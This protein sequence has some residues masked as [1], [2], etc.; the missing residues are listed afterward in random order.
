MKAEASILFAI[1]YSL[2][3]GEKTLGAV[4]HILRAGEKSLSAEAYILKAGRKLLEAVAY[5]LREVSYIPFWYQRTLKEKDSSLSP[6]LHSYFLIFLNGILLTS[7]YC[8]LVA[9]KT[10]FTY[11]FTSNAISTRPMLS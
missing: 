2:F 1:A 4:G 10:D 5:V 7:L 3:A 9:P 11:F 6:F 8:G